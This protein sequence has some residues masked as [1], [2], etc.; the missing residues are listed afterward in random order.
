M[1]TSSRTLF[2]SFVILVGLIAI[3]SRTANGQSR[4]LY[5]P[6]LTGDSADSVLTLMNASLEPA[7]VTLTARSYGGAVLNGYGIINPVTITLPASSSRALKAKE[8]FGQGLIAGWAELQSASPSISGA[9][10][11]LD[12]NQNAFDGAAINTAPAAV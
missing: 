12:S 2:F 10:F 9:F 4:S 11:L 8:L 5:I 7:T 1:L 3:S 6:V